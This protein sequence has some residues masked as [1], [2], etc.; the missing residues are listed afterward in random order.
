MNRWSAI[1]L[2]AGKGTRMK[3]KLP[4]VLHRA[5]GKSMVHHV[6]DCSTQA[7][8]ENLLTIVGFGAEEVRSE[9]IEISQIVEQKE[10][11][12]TGHA[13]QQCLPFLKE[14]TGDIA[15]LCGDTPLLRKET[16]VSLIEAHQNNP[17]VA[18]TVLTA[19]LPDPTG[20]GRIVR[21]A[22]Q[23]VGIVEQKDATGEQQIIK[24]INTGIYCFKSEKLAEA[25][26]SLTNDNAQG[27]YYL[28]DTL[29]Y[30][31][32]KGEKVCAVVLEDP[33]EAIGVNSRSQLAQ[34][35]K[36][37]RQRKNEELMAAGVTLVDPSSTFVDIGVEIGPDTII[38]PFTWIEGKTKIGENCTIGPNS[39]LHNVIVGDDVE[40]HFTYAH[41]C[42]VGDKV[43]AGPYVHLRPGTHLKAGVYVGN[44]MEIKNSTIGEGTK[45]SHLSYIGDAD[46][47]KEI[48][49]GCGTI[50]VNYDGQKKYRTV[51]EDRAFVGC[52]S[53]LV[54]PVTIGKDAY[55]AAGSTITKDVPPESLGVGR[56]RQ[57]N[58]E[59]WTKRKKNRETK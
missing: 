34:V 59:G 3:S 23:V 10:Q 45:L 56:A 39:R 28:T 55:V 7:G 15:I 51:I 33:D 18:A 27:E 37:L 20:Y 4:K 36:I 21:R 29:S 32:E 19:V 47:G 41:D 25:L 53:N 12:G 43:T 2:A 30:L 1:I 40:L 14:Y 50:T 38:Q 49:I 46:L 58:L 54:A 31:V 17:D 35:E 9:M 11:L 8:A 16:L 57:T 6:A 24:E 13:V 26:G 22:G 5:A 42:V 48:N 44:F 52:N